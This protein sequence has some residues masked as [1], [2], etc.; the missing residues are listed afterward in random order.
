[1][2][3]LFSAQVF[4]DDIVKVGEI[5]D[6]QMLMMQQNARKFNCVQGIGG[7]GGLGGAGPPNR[8]K[9]GEFCDPPGQNLGKNVFA[10]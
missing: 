4:N 6:E 9:W 3:F 10:T 2:K 1:M 8:S 7:L 5:K